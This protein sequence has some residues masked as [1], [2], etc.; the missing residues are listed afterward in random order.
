MLT[1]DQ[2]ERV[3]ATLV[4]DNALTVN[5]FLQRDYTEIF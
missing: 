4:D 3:L 2:R 5:S 1:E